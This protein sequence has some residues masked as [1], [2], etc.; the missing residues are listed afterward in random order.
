[1]PEKRIAQRVFEASVDPGRRAEQLLVLALLDD[2]HEPR[3]SRGELG[4]RFAEIPPERVDAALHALESDGVVCRAGEA[5][6]ASSAARRIDA[7]GLI[8]V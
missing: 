4:E 6:W 2:E 1:M 3:W 5:V 7:I 8:G